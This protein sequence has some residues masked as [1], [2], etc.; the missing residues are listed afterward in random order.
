MNIYFIEYAINAIL[1][2]RHKN[3]F[4]AA[5]FTILIFL[6][7]CIF[8]ITHSIKYELNATLKALPEI[9]VQNT[10]AGRIALIDTKY[11]DKI[12]TIYGVRDAV[13]RVWGY[14]YFEKAGV[15]FTL[16]GI[17]EFDTK[18]TKTLSKAAQQFHF[19]ENA[20]MIGAGVAKIVEK[21]YYK[22][23][24]NFIKMDGTI[25][26]VNI[27]GI[28]SADTE[29]ESNDMIVMQN[30]TLR[31]IFAIASDKA[32]DIVVHVANKEEIATVALRIKE[33]LPSAR[34]ITNK[35][36]QV[37][38]KKIFDYKSG[39]FLVLF[40]I[41][42]FTFFIIIYD[43]MS[44]LSS[45]Q[46]KEVG[47]L[48]A[49]GWSI[50]DIL[51]EKFYEGFIISIFSYLLGISLALF[52]VYILKAPLLKNLFIGYSDLKPSFDL[53]FVLDIQT[54]MLLFMLSIPIY[55][56]SIIIPSWKIATL[57]ADEVMR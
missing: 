45:E 30:D 29:L 53:P 46:K 36:M 26:R 27:S 23:Y 13:A 57:D 1:R 48:K 5:I 28:F 32:T 35:D 19:D 34:V 51:K 3:F 10:Q 14:Y 16:V 15:N 7:S 20:M 31:D 24:F 18:Y 9:I 4:I 38:Y 54:F 17:D 44:G 8:F 2:E 11:V 41:A 47:I 39:L 37:S 40:I 43:R 25:K 42:F 50:S 33:L 56:A 6:L 52:Y 12:L 21:N 55:I 22:N 49:V